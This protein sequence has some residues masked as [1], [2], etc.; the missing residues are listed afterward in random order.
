MVKEDKKG[1]VTIFIIIGILIVAGVLL[2]FLLR[3]NLTN[4]GR[5]NQVD[6]EVEPIYNYV[7]GC[8]EE[9]S[10]EGIFHISERGGYYEVPEEIKSDMGVPYYL[11]EK[12]VMMISKQEMESQLSRTIEERMS[13]C[14]D[15]SQFQDHDIN[16]GEISVDASV[17]REKVIIDMDFPLSI[18]KGEDTYEIGEF[19]ETREEKLGTIYNLVSEYIEEQ[20]DIEGFCVDCFLEISRNHDFS[21][22]NFINSEGSRI[23]II[24]DDNSRLNQGELIYSFAGKF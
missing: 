14:V 18:K 12:E 10:G 17:E 3:G 20:S 9:S 19:Q 23:F 16:S 11:K 2:F 21:I 8:L 13:S 22:D 6:Q 4:E 15:F 7:Q 1:Q 5:S 24:T